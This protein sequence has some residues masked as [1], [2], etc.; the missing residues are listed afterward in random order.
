MHRSHQSPPF[1][2]WCTKRGSIA[3][4]PESAFSSPLLT[5]HRVLVVY[6]KR[7]EDFWVVYF[8]PLRTGRGSWAPPGPRNHPRSRP[9]DSHDAF[10]FRDNTHTPTK[11]SPCLRPK[12]L[13]GEWNATAPLLDPPVPKPLFGQTR[14]KNQRQLLAR[15]DT[16]FPVSVMGWRGPLGAASESCGDCWCCSSYPPPPCCFSLSLSHAL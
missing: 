4:R 6:R 10:T 5:S 8:R 9:R 2:G 14:I 12:R 13:E 1:G 15:P 11:I 3:P 16:G 7:V